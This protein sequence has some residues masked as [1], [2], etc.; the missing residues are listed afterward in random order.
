MTPLSSTYS[1]AILMLAL[2][3]S[4]KSTPR[5][6]NLG[7]SAIIYHYDLQSCVARDHSK[8]AGQTANDRPD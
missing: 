6:S 1:K 4:R 5:R 3:T 7:L 8:T 2:D